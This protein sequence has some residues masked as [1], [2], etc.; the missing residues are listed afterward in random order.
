MQRTTSLCLYIYSIKVFYRIALQGGRLSLSVS[1][2][3]G[4]FL[5]LFQTYYKYVNRSTVPCLT[6]ISFPCFSQTEEST[7]DACSFSRT[8]YSF[9]WRSF[10]KQYKLTFNKFILF[11]LL[12]NPCFRL[13][14]R[15]RMPKT[16]RFYNLLQSPVFYSNTQFNI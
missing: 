6:N 2:N 16:L 5:S 4:M 12:F 10:L 13:K 11:L 7:T 15:F 9:L 1:C 3:V 8:S 14:C